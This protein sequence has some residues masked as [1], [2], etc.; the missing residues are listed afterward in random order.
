MRRS[1]AAQACSMTHYA[2][3]TDALGADC[4][5]SISNTSDSTF[6][7]KAADQQVDR[8]RGLLSAAFGGEEEKAVNELR[9]DSSDLCLHR[10]EGRMHL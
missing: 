5:T 1:S 4:D 8:P 10:S 2:R 3:S 6:G 9:S 7:R